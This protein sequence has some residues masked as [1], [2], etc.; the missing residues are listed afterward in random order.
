MM[1][2]NDTPTYTTLEEI[3]QRKQELRLQLDRDK[4]IVDQ[5][6]KGLS[7]K[8]EDTTRGQVIANIISNSAMAIDAFLMVRK[9]KKNYGGIF[10][11]FKK[12]KS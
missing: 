7:V 6:W 2:R 11:F 12:K 1:T 3:N 5:L 4:Q 9:L 8:R 10:Q